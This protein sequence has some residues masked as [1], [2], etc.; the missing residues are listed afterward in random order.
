[1]PSITPFLWFDADLVEPIT[2]YTSIFPRASRPTH[3]PTSMPDRSTPQPSSCAANSS[4][5]ST[6]VRRMRLHGGDLDVR[7]RRHPGRGR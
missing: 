2:F 4:C 3:D 1:M 5:C 7:Q 6:A